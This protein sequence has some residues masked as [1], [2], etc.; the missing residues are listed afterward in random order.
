MQTKRHQSRQIICGMIGLLIQVSSLSLAADPPPKGA[1]TDGDPG[2]TL[3][4]R[5]HLGAATLLGNGKVIVAGGLDKTP[6]EIPAIT[7]A[8]LYDPATKRWSVTGPLQTPR[9]SLDAITLASG[10]ALFAGGATAFK[11][12]AT[13]ATAEVFDPATESFS[14]TANNLSVAR[15]SFGIT[16]IHDGK[17]FITGGNTAGNNLGGTGVTAVDIYDPATNRFSPAA[18]MNSGRSLHAQVTLG[19][20]RVV[21]IGGAQNDAE[22]FDPTTNKWTISK[23]TLPT[24]LK[25]TKAFELY[26]GKVFVAGGQNTVDGVTTD[27]TW[28]FDPNSGQF[29]PGP[30]M[31]GFNYAE[32]GVQVGA[33]DYTAFDLF[34]TG[35]RLRGRY[36]LIAG[37][38]HDPLEGPDVE[39]FSSVLYDAQ[40]NK[41]LNMGRMPFIHDD[42]AESLLRMNSAGHP[43]LLLF[44]GNST[45]G[46]SRFEFLMKN[47]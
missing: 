4:D 44:G 1:W 30:S 5:H 46:T 7:T 42:H 14:Y 22:V 32:A 34:P 43:E 29:T 47:P 3:K 8:E 19:D 38:E 13:V 31:A 40:Q 37:G 12:P 9:W 26:N 15:H 11:V 17:V 41:F 27:A 6:P 39:L 23:N 25:D 33:S 36:I 10:K 28:F 24:T 21:V 35:H 16:L 45:L 18:P 2:M 20:G